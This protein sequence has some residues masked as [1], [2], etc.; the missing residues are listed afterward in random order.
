[1]RIYTYFALAL[2]VIA[3]TSC[4]SSEYKFK[5]DTSKK[6]TLGQKA[7]IKFEQVAGQKIDSVQLFI[8]KKRVNKTQTNIEINT[9]DFGV[10]KHS[11]TA[12]AFYPHKS[13]K[14]TNSIEVL[15]KNAPNVYSYKIVNTYPHDKNAY[16]QGLEFKN[17]FL[18]E[19]TGRRGESSL[20]KVAL[21]TGEVL[22]KIDLDKKYFGEGMTI[23]NQKIYW[24]TW[25]ARKG[26]IYD[27]E[28]FK[29][30]GEFK[31]E[32]SNQGW[33]LT[34]NNTE[35]IKS[36]GTN[37]IW[38]LN[39]DNQQEKRSIQVYTNKY[40]VDNLNE[41]E[42]INGKIYANK[43][44]QNSILIINPETGV[45]EGVANLNGLRDIV[46][47]NQTLDPNDDV[48]NG[49]AFD[50]ENNRLFVTGKHWDKLF[51]IELIKQ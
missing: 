34:H 17:G 22:Q 9:A 51:E 46:A 5:L 28:T 33:G 50:T 8:N 39:T 10:G 42:L 3:V 1:M 35:L 32:N 24:L 21:K 41:I 30:L 40:S 4:N 26:F 15:A 48:L 7:S 6:T 31:Y 20:R 16:T 29:Q 12:L 18:Y 14:I 11:V 43:W 38:F 49:I 25:Q 27:L 23:F 13:T 36:D 44:Q 37:K 45:V 19:T 2:S 47:K